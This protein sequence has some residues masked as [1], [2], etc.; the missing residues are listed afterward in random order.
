MPPII[1]LALGALAAGAIV[2]PGGERGAAHQLGARSREN[3]ARY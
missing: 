2:E 3:G 1:V